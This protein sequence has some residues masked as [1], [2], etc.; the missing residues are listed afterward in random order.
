M[1]TVADLRH[2]K[3]FTL[4]IAFSSSKHH[5][6]FEIEA[7]STEPSSITSLRRNV[8]SLPFQVICCEVRRVFAA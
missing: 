7:V 5:M 2:E 1:S 8:T 3:D 6:K 4:L